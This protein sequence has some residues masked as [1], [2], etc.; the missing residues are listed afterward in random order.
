MTDELQRKMDALRAAASKLN[1]ATNQAAKTVSALDQFLGE[2]LSLGVSARSSCFHQESA[3][4]IDDDEDLDAGERSI[5]SYLAYGRVAGTF[6]LHVLDSIQ[7]RTEAGAWEELQVQETYWSSCSREVKL[8]SFACLPELLETLTKITESMASGA[9]ETA[10]A[11]GTPSPPVDRKAKGTFTLAVRR[12]QRWESLH[13]A[14][15]SLEEAISEAEFHFANDSKRGTTV[16]SFQ[17][18][19]SFT[20]RVYRCDNSPW[21]PTDPQS[22]VIVEVVPAGNGQNGVLGI[23]KILGGAPENGHIKPQA[24]MTGKVERKRSSP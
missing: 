3:P 11:V 23:Y 16:K 19:G 8:R 1:A 4:R 7:R 10:K 20:T 6:R 5:F 15:G 14:Y 18:P 13:P 24:E 21:D 2:E 12:D 9:M 22:P 17:P